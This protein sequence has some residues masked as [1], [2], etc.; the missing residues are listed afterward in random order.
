MIDIRL[1]YIILLITAFLAAGLSSCSSEE[2]IDE[3]EGA[4][5]RVLKVSANITGSR[6]TRAYQAEGRIE[7]GIYYLAYPNTSSQ[8]KVATVDFDM[9]SAVSPGLGIVTTGA[10]SELKWSEI[11]GSPV[12]FYL[13]NVPPAMD[14][15]NTD[16]Q[17]VTFKYDNPFVAG[18]FDDIDGTNDLLWGDKSV[19]RDTKSISFDLHHNMSRVKVQVKIAHKET[20]VENV[21]LTDATVKI[22]NLRPRTLSYDRTTGNLALDT[23]S[24]L[25]PVTIVDPAQTK[26]NWT[27]IKE[28]PDTTTYTSPDIVL[29]PQ[30]LLENE[31]RPQLVITLPDGKEY[32]GILPHAMLIASS[33]DGSLSYPVTL[34]FLKEY[35]L[36]IRT[37]ITEEP[38]ELAFMPVY[39]VGWVD[40]GQF[41]EEAHQSGIYTTNEF[42]RLIDYYKEDNQYQLVRY[43]YL[44]TAPDSDKKMWNFDFWSSVVLDYNKIH[45]MMKSGTVNQTAGLPYDY[46]FSF[47]NYTIYVQNGDDEASRRSVTQ[48]Q[49]KGICN[50]SIS[51]N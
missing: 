31:D 36:T 29:P 12:N 5:A 35:V 32:S 25:A 9:E 50:G 44:T 3:D 16:S 4:F 46:T 43:G 21:D 2:I 24:D 33:T 14:S 13:D 30:A 51:W 19:T 48:A 40:K 37:V 7:E 27:D 6:H 15:L 45:G 8:Y 49:L 26:Y 17:I 28:K 34:A 11:G 10:G 39:V 47:N 38:P 18:V 42:Y 41:T 22:T 1:K 20:T 23:I